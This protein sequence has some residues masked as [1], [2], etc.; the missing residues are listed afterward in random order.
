MPDENDSP[1]EIEAQS[2][3][4]ME[5]LGPDVPLHFSAFHPDWKMTSTPATPPQTLRAA[6]RIAMQAGLRYVYT[7][8]I[9]DPAGQSTYCHG[10]GATLIGRDWYDLTA[11]NLSA[12]GHCAECG[13]LCAGVLDAGHGQWGRRRRSIS[14][15]AFAGS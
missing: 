10:C 3:W 6:R 12:G 1:G 4:L 15:Q 13:T 14:V 9:H 5:H 11:W 7:G 2:R 8:N